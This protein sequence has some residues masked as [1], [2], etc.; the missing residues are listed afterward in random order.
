V[1]DPYEPAGM[2]DP[3]VVA[4]RRIATDVL[5]PRAQEVDR[6]EVPRSHLRAIADAGL[7]GLHAAAEDGGAGAA[8]AAIRAVT[9][10][11]AGADCATWFVQVQH[12]SPVAMLAA[13]ET[14]VRET[15]LRP[16]AQGDRIAG[17]AFSHLRRRPR[18][19]VTATRTLAGWRFDGTA[20]WYTGWGL[21]DLLLLAGLSEQDEVVFALTE[22]APSP[23]LQASPPQ[24]MVAL[25]ASRTVS[26]R[27]DGVLV[28]EQDV[29]LRRP[30]PD[31]AR[32]DA[33]K[34]ANVNPAVF[35]ITATAQRLLGATAAASGEPA[36]RRA[37]TAIRAALESVRRRCYRLLDEVPAEEAIAERL[38]ARAD[39][40]VLMTTATT[41]LVAAGAGRSLGADA[42]AQRLAREALFLTVQAQTA[43]V[44]AATLDRLGAQADALAA[45]GGGL[46][47]T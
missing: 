42:P 18:R 35:G 3:L 16:M 46:R 4:A 39:A 36:A 38:A 8:P 25:S 41:A 2:P 37:A 31:W 40:L 29:L 19:L 17:I 32:A 33:A 22:A 15:L 30:W 1:P 44:R 6:T 10:T 9:E 24:R 34:S 21:N 14:P 23:Q 27:L 43:P 13:A 5:E 11:L 47:P 28:P 26:L 45:P 20:P 12:H 7:L